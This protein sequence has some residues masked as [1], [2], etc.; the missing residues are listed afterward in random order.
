MRDRSTLLGCAL[1]GHATVSR[2]EEPKKSPPPTVSVGGIAPS[3][4]V[5]PLALA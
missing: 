5:Q 3:L 1:P 4:P 2:V